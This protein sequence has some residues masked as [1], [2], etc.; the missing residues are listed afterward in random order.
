MMGSQV[1]VHTSQCPCLCPSPGSPPPMYTGATFL[2]YTWE[3]GRRST[4]SKLGRS[5]EY[6][7]PRAVLVGG[8]PR[9]AR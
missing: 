4:G 2:V 8:R 5:N 3:S 9:T 1:Q 7:C 6:V